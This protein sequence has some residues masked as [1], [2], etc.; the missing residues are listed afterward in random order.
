MIISV[1]LVPTVKPDT[2]T[3]PALLRN[4]ANAAVPVADAV[5]DNG[6]PESVNTEPDTVP[7]VALSVIVARTPVAPDKADVPM[8]SEPAV[9]VPV[10][11]AAVLV[12]IRSATNYIRLV[13]SVAA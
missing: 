12:A 8:T 10:E 7:G 11:A 1:P 2:M 5:A 6:T 3:V 4:S 13:L 9:A